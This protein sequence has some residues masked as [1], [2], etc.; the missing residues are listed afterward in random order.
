MKLRD[1]T[2]YLQDILDAIDDIRAFTED[3][4]F[5]NFASDRKTINAVI[6][7]IE[8]TPRSHGTRWLTCEIS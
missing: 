3:M 1:H 2:D 5:Q 7:S 4:S 8:V 6:R